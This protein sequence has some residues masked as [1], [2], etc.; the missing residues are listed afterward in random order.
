MQWKFLSAYRYLLIISSIYITHKFIFCP[1]EL[2]QV[3]KHDFKVSLYNAFPS[4]SYSS[5][6]FFSMNL[7]TMLLNIQ[8]FINTRSSRGTAY[9]NI[10]TCLSFPCFTVMCR[11]LS[12]VKI[13]MSSSIIILMCLSLLFSTLLS[14]FI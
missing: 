7:N 3:G 2:T 13:V 10:T 1:P 5:Q 14:K 11:T 12:N 4:I 9:L 6:N 8:I